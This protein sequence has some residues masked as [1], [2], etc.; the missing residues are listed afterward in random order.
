M[1]NG[2]ELHS[3]IHLPCVSYRS[4]P[5]NTLEE[6]GEDNVPIL[7]L[8]IPREACVIVSCDLSVKQLD[9]RAMS[10]I[11]HGVPLLTFGIL[12]PNVKCYLFWLEFSGAFSAL[13]PIYEC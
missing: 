10:E 7:I 12:F 2:G 8:E 11:I 9:R 13:N 1:C 6:A 3:Y 5:S 4:R